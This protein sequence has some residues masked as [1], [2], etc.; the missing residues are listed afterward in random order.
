MFRAH[1]PYSPFFTS[2]LFS[3]SLSSHD[4]QSA[5]YL[6]VV[7][8]D[9]EH[10]RSF[11]SLDLAESLSVCSYSV[12]R[13][14]PRHK[15][16]ISKSSSRD[17]L[18]SMPSPK[19][20]PSTTLPPPPGRSTR[21]ASAPRL[22]SLPPLPSLEL[23][24]S[25]RKSTSSLKQ[26]SAR[27]IATRQPSIASTRTRLR[28]RAAALALLEGRQGPQVPSLPRPSRQLKNFMSMSDDEDDDES[29]ILPLSDPE[30]DAMDSFDPSYEPEDIVLPVLPPRSS[31][32]SGAVRS[33]HSKHGGRKVSR[34]R[35][36]HKSEKAL[37]WFPLKSFIDFCNENDDDTASTNWNWRSFIEFANVS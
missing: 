35:T 21:I 7:F 15:F 19:P 12:R 25:P 26:P 4:D 31:Q 1:S 28:N 5:I 24:L 18:R 22:P 30:D 29:D 8:S 33:K 11:L 10:Y 14:L 3:E 20:V 37:E 2:G 23:D 36:Q 34:R 16:H 13:T 27:H 17:S 32:L 9:D 6:D